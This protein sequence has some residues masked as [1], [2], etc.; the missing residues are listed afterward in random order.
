MADRGAATG[1]VLDGGVM[2]AA[3][4]EWLA[5]TGRSSP[6]V[7]PG[8]PLVGD[9]RKSPDLQVAHAAWNGITHAVDHLHAVRSLLG[10]AR[11]LHPYAP[12]TLLRSAIEN[13]ATAVWLLAPPQRSERVRRRLKLARHEAWES[14]QVRKLVPAEVFEGRRT[15][16]ERIAEIR[17]LAIALGLDPNDVCGQF[18]YE[19]VVRQAGEATKLGG[20]LS[21]LMWRLCSGLTHGRYWASLSFLQREEMA[22]TT[23]AGVLDV[24]LTTDVDQVLTVVQV[25]FTFTNAALQLYDQRRRSPYGAA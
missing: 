3:I 11:V 20:D 18:G 8:S 22:R 19:S 16:E 25:P 9:A 5:I 1:L 10:D 15:A 14:G 23:E 21:A 17:S 24:R 6:E 4:D 2:F 12:Y 7:E 13:A